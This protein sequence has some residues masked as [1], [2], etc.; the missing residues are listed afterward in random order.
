MNPDVERILRK[1]RSGK[2]FRAR[3]AT[4]IHTKVDDVRVS[5][6]VDMVNDPIQRNHRRGRFYEQKELGQLRRLFPAGGTFVDIGAN[7]GNH[8]LYAALLLKA[9]RVV[10]VEPNRPAYR[11]LAHNVVINRLEDIVDLTR[12]GVGLSDKA[13]GGYAMQ[14]RERNLGGAKML[15]GEGEL[16]V[17]SGDELL[18]DES[19]DMIKIDVEGMEMKV[20]DG[21][22]QT[23]AT[24]RPLLLVEVDNENEQAFFDWVGA[25][26]YKLE[27]TVQRYRLNK[28][29]L[30][31]PEEK[32]ETCAAE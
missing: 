25:H 26:G 9:A 18:A 20:L 14:K 4:L 5:F 7:V 22:E 31:L 6:C 3:N 2:P 8:T 21:L 32:A 28:N 12:L 30:L 27:Q 15:P 23:I 11:L 10:P 24:H 29:H 19:P 13:G 1:L 16:A 17:V